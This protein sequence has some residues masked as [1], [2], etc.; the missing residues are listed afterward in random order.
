MRIDQMIRELQMQK[1]DL[2][3]AI[4]LLESFERVSLERRGYKAPSN[5]GI[6]QPEPRRRGRKF[7]TL[8]ERRAVS[9]RMKL[10]WSTRKREENS[11]VN[12]QPGGVNSSKQRESPPGTRR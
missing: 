1:K 4:E 8:A 2:D 6:T 5:P 9:E 12:A 3:R 10:Y 11:A 7:M